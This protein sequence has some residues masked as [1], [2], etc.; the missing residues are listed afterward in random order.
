MKTHTQNDLQEN[1]FF[2]IRR[3]LGNFRDTETKIRNATAHEMIAVNEKM[4]QKQTQKTS[5]EILVQIGTLL[6]LIFPE[7]F[8]KN[9]FIYDDIN[10]LILESLD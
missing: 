1:K 10:K 3:I 2:E 7:E 9:D 4:I 8:S 6:E 5:Q